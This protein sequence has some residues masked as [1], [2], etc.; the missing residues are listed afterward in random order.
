MGYTT[1]LPVRLIRDDGSVTAP[2]EGV[3]WYCDPCAPGARRYEV[4]GC[5]LPGTRWEVGKYGPARGV[6]LL[7][8]YAVVEDGDDR[9]L[10]VK[11]AHI[12]AV[13]AARDAL[14]VAR[15][16]VFALTGERR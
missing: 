2:L 5:Y 11:R 9:G 6:T 7:P 3:E 8:W 13:A 12:R 10:E 4:T 1:S 15:K 14:D 16:T